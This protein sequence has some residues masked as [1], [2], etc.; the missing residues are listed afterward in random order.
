MSA[1]HS[2]PSSPYEGTETTLWTPETT[3]RAAASIRPGVEV[4]AIRH[5]TYLDHNLTPQPHTPP[6][7]INEIDVGS[8]GFVS[9]YILIQS[10]PDGNHQI[11]AG[12]DHEI[13]LSKVEEKMKEVSLADPIRS[14]A[15]LTLSQYAAFEM[16][17]PI[18]S[19]GVYLRFDDIQDAGACKYILEQ[20]DFKTSYVDNY[21]F[22][23]AKSQDTGAMDEFEGQIRV[24]IA[25]SRAV[26][27]GDH[28]QA[29][30]NLNDLKVLHQEIETALSRFGSVRDFVHTATHNMFFVFRVEFFSVEV[31]NRTRASLLD[32]PL[33]RQEVCISSFLCFAHAN[34]SQGIWTWTVARADNWTGPRAANSPH[35]RFPRVD[36]RGRFME[37]RHAPLTNAPAAPPRNDEETRHNQVLRHRI[38]EGSDVRTTIMLRNIP[39]KLDWVSRLR[40][41]S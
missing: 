19:R 37:F 23:L 11:A 26:I 1:R 40:H 6:V 39:N 4:V 36:D 9:R 14:F 7:F 21:T 29:I 22:A 10:I 28:H 8:D 12:S 20:H 24:E 25:V 33:T 30:F 27:D 17:V 32:R 31:A 5:T 18:Y 34:T 35:R 15:S 2:P 38:V 41:L 13:E 3:R 16:C